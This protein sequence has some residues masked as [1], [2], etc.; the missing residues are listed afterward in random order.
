MNHSSPKKNISLLRA[1]CNITLGLE[2]IGGECLCVIIELSHLPVSAFIKSIF[3]LSVDFNSVFMVG[4]VLLLIG[5]HCERVLS[6][7]CLYT[8]LWCWFTHRYSRQG[9][10]FLT[11]NW[12][13]RH[14]KIFSWDTSF[15]DCSA[16]VMSEHRL[17]DLDWCSADVTG[18]EIDLIIRSENKQHAPALVR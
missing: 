6:P 18:K 14:I 11:T 17:L 9:E 5:L 4:S 1:F 8:P 13:R 3:S 15:V 12:I 10:D 7:L 16:A 2:T